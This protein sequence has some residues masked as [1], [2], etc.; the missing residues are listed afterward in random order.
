MILSGQGVIRIKPCGVAYWLITLFQLP[1][2]AAFTGYIIYAKRKKHVVHSQEDGKVGRP[3]LSY[4]C[5]GKA[6]KLTATWTVRDMAKQVDLVQGTMDTL[7]SLTFPLAAFVTGVLSGLF[8]IGG[9]LLLNPVLL[10]IGINPQVYQTFFSYN[11]PT[12]PMRH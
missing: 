9:G 11:V 10:Q 5:C 1:A 4:C 8:G 3:V 2:A 6:A 7:P 12:R